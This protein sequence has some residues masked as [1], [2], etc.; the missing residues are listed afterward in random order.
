MKSFK[1]I[2]H[3]LIIGLSLLTAQCKKND[4][5][6]NKF[7][8]GANPEVLS[9]LANASITAGK[10]L[11]RDAIIKYDPDGLI[12]LKF[13]QDSIFKLSADS[14]LKDISL[15]KSSVN[16]SMGEI[17]L[18]GINEQSV[19]PLMDFFGSK[20]TAT[21]RVF[22]SKQGK[23][24]IFPSFNTSSSKTTNIAKSVNFELLKIS[25]G[26]LVFDIKNNLPTIISEIQITIIDNLPTPHTLGTA[27]IFN[28]PSNAS[29]RDSINLAGVNLSNDL[30][31][32]LPVTKADQS[33]TAVIIDTLSN[34]N[35]SVI[36]NNLKCIGGRAIINSQSINPQ[37]LV[38]DLTDPTSDARLR[39]ILF[40]SANIPVT[41]ESKFCSDVAIN[42]DFPDASKLGNPISPMVINAISKSTTNS[43]INFTN[44]NLFLGA[45]TTKDYNV[46]RTNV[47]VT[48]KASTGMVNFDSSDNIKITL[49]PSAAKFDY[50][51]GYLGTKTFDININDLDVSQLAKLG[52]GIRME[53]PI[54]DIYVD[55]SFGV[56]ILVRLV[57]TSKDDKNNTLPM[58]VD[59]MKF[60]F[61]TIA[62]KGQIKSQTFV[63]NK[64]NS[65]IVN[66][67]GMPASTFTIVGKAIM[68]PKGFVSYT[69]HIVNTS[70]IVVG[71]DADIPMTFTAKDFS[72]TDTN[73][74]GATLQGKTNFD[75]L[76][77]K[78]KTINGFPLDGSLDLIFTD[79]KYAKIDSLMNVTLLKS[80][81]PDA[82]GRVITTSENMTSFLMKNE[83]LGKLDA[84]KCKYIMIRVNFNTYNSGTVPVSIYTDS[85]LDVSIA[86]RGKIK[87]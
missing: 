25:K 64:S 45:S 72:Y 82:N 76:E 24:D 1:K 19:V 4:L 26:F 18:P 7:K 70:N 78:I 56:P 69:D 32:I 28:I 37:N 83:L 11:K 57:I 77:L 34:V 52:K 23:L 86:F 38:L 51:D 10:I 50:L 30:S 15:S 35:L 54:M 3:I 67:L 36:G 13:K 63:I 21:K 22:R 16:M 29:G 40:G 12:H 2:N 44:T 5:N 6:F 61:P 58:N 60:P 59:S 71:F 48:I 62:E 55:N 74:N 84:Q 33:P 66:C 87:I 49:D 65:N 47:S 31:F 42:V 81:I 17:S 20:D 75:F 46:L 73:E 79:D 39:N 41:I 53:N 85:K 8:N 9:P 43:N 14:I 80:G 27:K 68:N